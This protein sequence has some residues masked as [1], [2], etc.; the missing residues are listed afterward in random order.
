M[1]LGKLCIA[2]GPFGCNTSS[3]SS[4]IQKRPVNVQCRQVHCTDSVEGCIPMKFIQSK[5]TREVNPWEEVGSGNTD[6]FGGGM[7]TFLRRAHIRA[8]AHKICGCSGIDSFGKV[9]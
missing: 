7:Q 3:N 6:L 9:R 2:I 4:C 5:K 1:I 8:T